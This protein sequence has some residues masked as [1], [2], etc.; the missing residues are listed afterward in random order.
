MKSALILLIFLTFQVAAQVADFLPTQKTISK[1]FGLPIRVD[2]DG[3]IDYLVGDRNLVFAPG[4]QLGWDSNTVQYSLPEMASEFLLKSPSESSGWMEYKRRRYEYGVGLITVLQ[5]AFR[6]GLSPYKGAKF[7]MKRLKMDKA[8]ETSNRIAIPE[9]LEE[10]L[11]WAPGDEGIYQTYGGIQVFGGMDVLIFNAGMITLGWQNQFIIS[12][13]RMKDS[14]LLTI[15][16]E[17]LDRKSFRAG[18]EL[19][20]GSLTQYKG[21][22]FKAS[23]ALNFSEPSHHQLFRDALEGRLTNL[24]KA[25]SPERKKI[26][27]KGH[28]ISFSWGIPGIIGHINSLGSY[29]VEDDEQDY[30]LEVMQNKRSGLLVSPTF[31]QRFVYHNEESILLMWTTDMKKS[32]PGKLRKH[33]F[34][35]ARAVGFKGFEMELEEKNYGTVIGEVGVVITKDDVAKFSVLDSLEVSQSLKARCEELNLSCAKD[36]QIRSIMKKF[37]GA[38]TR[39]WETRKKHLGILLVKE[40][41]LLHALLKE[42]RNTK[43]AYFKFL[44]DRYQ[45]LEGLTLLSLE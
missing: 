42:S 34:G 26:E 1:P 17:K 39:E 10:I 4:V 6:L 35:P 12:I 37:T 24:E 2:L 21:K 33:F 15:A 7:S 30:Y 31:H 14:I 44:S 5:K 29:H 28:D 45:S 38:M 8:F 11:A 3:K 25:L 36:S 32:A 16:E 43:E 22:Q 23:F 27:W 20:N 41:A 9:K 18:I 13:Q 40:P 19:L